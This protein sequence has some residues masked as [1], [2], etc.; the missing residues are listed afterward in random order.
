MCY[1][2]CKYKINLKGVT[3]LARITTV[4][5]QKGGVAKSTTVNCLATGLISKGFKVLVIDTD[6]QGNISFTMGANTNGKGLYECMREEE[7]AENLIQKTNQGDIL[8]ST[9]L[10]TAADM[11]FT[12]V[13][14][15]F[16]AAKNGNILTKQKKPVK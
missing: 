2:V 15:N 8:P 12:R 4:I 13:Q 7:N 5:N 9:L 16:V 14:Q 11:E 1:N 3:S 6:P 10:L